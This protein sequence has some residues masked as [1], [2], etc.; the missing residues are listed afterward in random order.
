MELPK[1]TID[2]LRETT[3][4]NDLVDFRS[5]CLLDDACILLSTL[6]TQ[7]PNEEITSLWS[8]L[9]E[10]LLAFLDGRFV[11]LF[12]SSCDLECHSCALIVSEA[13]FRGETCEMGTRMSPAS[14]H[15]QH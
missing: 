11:C 14:A 1:D 4:C 3:Q 15:I 6:E 12:D 10:L 5:R 8:E 7:Q 2:L 13:I 9:R